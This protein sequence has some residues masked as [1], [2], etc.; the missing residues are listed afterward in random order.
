MADTGTGSTST[1]G[2]DTGT[3]SAD[4]GTGSSSGAATEG[5]TS[6]VGLEIAGE[7]LEEFAPGM[8]MTHVIDETRWDQ[9]S[10]F[11]DAVFHVDAYDNAARTVVAQGDAANEFN[12][13]LWSRFDWTWDGDALYYCTAVFDAPTAEDALAAPAPDSGDLAAGCG[14]FPW[15]PLVPV[16]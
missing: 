5:T 2:N 15:S 10:D 4:T 3:S 14:G 9:L 16:R 1:A 11:G 6:A 13:E 12:P 8:G 7:W